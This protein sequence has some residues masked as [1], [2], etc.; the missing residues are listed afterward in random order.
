MIS[1]G[2][3]GVITDRPDIARHVLA[4]RAGFSPVERL[5]VEVAEYLGVPTVSTGQ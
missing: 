5:L 3:D 1:R 2:V 4:E